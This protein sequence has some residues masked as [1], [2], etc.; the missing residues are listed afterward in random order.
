MHRRQVQ[1]DAHPCPRRQVAQHLDRQPVRQQQVVGRLQGAG[2]TARAGSVDAVLMAQMRG[3]L[4]L[5]VGD[6][7]TDAIAEAARHLLGK[8]REIARRIARRPAA[9]GLQPLRQVPVVQGRQR[10][11]G[12]LQQRVGQGVVEVESGAVDRAATTRIDARPGDREA[13]GV[14]AEARHQ[15]HVLAVAVVVVAGVRGGGAVRHPPR[16][17]RE[18]VPDRVAAAAFGGAAFDLAG[19][20]GGAPQEAVRKQRHGRGP[21]LATAR[22]GR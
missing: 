6:P 1:G 13:V 20:A 7:Q 11:D 21:G 2:E 9:A 22:W 3:D 19:G 14:Q 12:M 17:A 5:V 15:R 16:T 8:V 4:R 10:G 18:A